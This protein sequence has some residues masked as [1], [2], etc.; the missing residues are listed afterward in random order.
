MGGT[1][2]F[3]A[4]SEDGG[5][6][7]IDD[8]YNVMQLIKVVTGNANYVYEN[9]ENV[10]Y[11]NVQDNNELIW[12]YGLDEID[13]EG[14]FG[15]QIERAD[16]NRLRTRLIRKKYYNANDCWSDRDDRL[17]GK[18][19]FYGFK[20]TYNLQK[21]KELAGM[22]VYNE[23][24]STLFTT[25]KKTLKIIYMCDSKS[26]VEYE[27]GQNNPYSIV[28]YTKSPIIAYRRTGIL[29]PT[30]D[31]A[32]IQR[33]IM[34]HICVNGVNVNNKQTKIYSANI[35]CTSRHRRPTAYENL[36]YNTKGTIIGEI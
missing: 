36:H 35:D 17:M 10:Y 25:S 28:A 2:Y 26:L 32:D 9:N 13:G 29:I 11:I 20:N 6:I 30:G 7:S 19:K 27:Y 23:D 16:D 21:S 5:L 1:K 8:S 31:N 15:L 12:G 3:E 34:S 22:E 33:K 18:L 14:E 4:K 24:G